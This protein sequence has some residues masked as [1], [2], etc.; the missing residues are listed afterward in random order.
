[1]NFRAK[2]HTRRW[3]LAA[4]RK[5][6]A[7]AE[8]GTCGVAPAVANAIYSA[9]GIR[10]QEYPVKLEKL[11]DRLPTRRVRHEVKGSHE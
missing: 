6:V 9:T 1:L 2:A 11:I 10:V 7:P 3:P 5:L 4:S 8:L